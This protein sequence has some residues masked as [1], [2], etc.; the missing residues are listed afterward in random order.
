MELARLLILAEERLL[1]RGLARLLQPAY[2]THVIESFERACRF[3]GNGRPEIVL[4]IGDR[5]D[6]ETAVA[7]EQVR[8]SHPGV[9]LCIIA[10]AADPDAL[11]SLLSH[12]PEAVAV[13]LRCDTLDL[14]S[15]T[16]TLDD[17]LS[18]RSTLEPRVLKQLLA[19][20]EN[21]DPLKRL[22]S[23]EQQVLELIAS[24]LRNGEIARRLCKSEK[25]IE[26][27]VGQVFVKLGLDYGTR[28]HIDRRV[29]AARIFLACRPQNVA[30]SLPN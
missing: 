25:A 2:E 3:A 30:V 13:L 11:R 4:W 21:Q 29:A 18:G 17:V 12:A 10:H 28:P 15:V 20:N 26:K 6:G 1:S 24:G 5:V 8:G 14:G 27:Q 23:T 16:A 19:A 9:L 22:T 7:L